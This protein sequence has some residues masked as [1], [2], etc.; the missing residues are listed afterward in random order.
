[1]E[2]SINYLLAWGSRANRNVDK[3]PRI[4]CSFPKTM[5]PSLISM[6]YDTFI[7]IPFLPGTEYSISK[8]FIDAIANDEHILIPF[9]AKFVSRIFFI[10]KLI[11]DEMFLKSW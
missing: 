3:K 7:G 5:L 11:G 6:C 2:C 8:E 9:L 1:M 4:N 10:F